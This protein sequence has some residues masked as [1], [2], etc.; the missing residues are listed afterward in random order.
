VPEP[1]PEPAV[2]VA[3]LVTDWARRI[4]AGNGQSPAQLQRDL[5]VDGTLVAS[6]GD[7]AL[8]PPP[9]GVRQGSN[10]PSGRCT[11]FARVS[12]APGPDVAVDSVLLRTEPE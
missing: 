2:G 5:G 11:V 6:F 9:A 8:E 1:A 4:A 12:T 10:H 7:M 3:D